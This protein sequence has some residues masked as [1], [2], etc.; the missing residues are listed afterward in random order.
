VKLKIQ[1]PGQ[2]NRDT[3]IYLDGKELSGVYAIS[4]GMDV[5]SVNNAVIEFYPSEIEIEGDFDVKTTKRIVKIREGQ[6]EK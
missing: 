4:V 5:D 6:H 1:A 2:T 3:K